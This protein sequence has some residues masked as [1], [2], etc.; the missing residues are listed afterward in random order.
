ML[1]HRKMRREDISILNIRRC[2]FNVRCRSVSFCFLDEE[3]LVSEV[4]KKKNEE[5]FISEM[6]PL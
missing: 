4:L 2:R 5:S 3:S 6:L 1:T